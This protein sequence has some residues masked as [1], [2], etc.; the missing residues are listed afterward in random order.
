MRP[1][2]VQ[3]ESSSDVD[4][5]L[6]N[7]HKH[8]TNVDFKLVHLAPDRTKEQRRLHSGIVKQMKE[9]IKQDKRYF[10]RDNKVILSKLTGYQYL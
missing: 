3:F 1:I 6:R 9:L 5:I 4:I 7:T 2:K 8:K 10:F